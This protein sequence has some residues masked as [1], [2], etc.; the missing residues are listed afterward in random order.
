MF[1]LP[2][3]RLLHSSDGYSIS[4]P[5]TG[6]KIYLSPQSS[7]SFSVILY[8]SSLPVHVTSLLC[9]QATIMHFSISVLGTSV[10]IFMTSAIAQPVFRHKTLHLLHHH[11]AHPHHRLNTGLDVSDL[12]VQKVMKPILDSG[13]STNS[14]PTADELHLPTTAMPE[15]YVGE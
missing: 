15:S 13:S 9:A 6:T 1:P 4:G 12:D 8:C 10:L 14:A 3:D 5:A 2:C 7:I 11:H